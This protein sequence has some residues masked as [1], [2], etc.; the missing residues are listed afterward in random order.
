MAARET[1]RNDQSLLLKQK[2]RQQ[3]RRLEKNGIDAI[4]YDQGSDI[5]DEEM[6][7]GR[8]QV[9]ASDLIALLKSKY[10]I[11]DNFLQIG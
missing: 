1:E 11:C 8:Q 4:L 6:R 3:I 5:E 7:T 10:V 9:G 2:S